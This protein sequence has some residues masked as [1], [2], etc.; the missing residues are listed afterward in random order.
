[1]S[2]IKIFFQ[3]YAELKSHKVF[4]LQFV[5]GLLFLGISL[6]LNYAANTYTAAHGSSAVTDLILDNIPTWRVDAVFFEGI[7][8][9]VLFIALLA[10]Y[11]PKRIPFL[12]KSIA[13]FVAV[14]SFFLVLTHLAPPAH[15]ALVP[16]G[17]FM[18]KLASGSGSDLF[19]SGHTGLPFLMALLFWEDKVLRWLFLCASVVFGAAVLLGHLHY[20][21]DV[22]SAFFITYGIY[23][24]AVRLFRSDYRLFHGNL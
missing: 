2:K 24:A 1:M 3:R 4:Y 21:I 14:R 10:L 20:S 11:Q 6:L 18:E 23:Q 19:F 17:N 12:L 5:L 15:P 8:G 22:F 13:L 16:S 7:I 9:F